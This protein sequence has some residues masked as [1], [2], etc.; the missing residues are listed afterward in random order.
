[1]L[2]SKCGTD[3]PNGS[4]FCFK[5]GTPLYSQNIE[6][7]AEPERK[8]HSHSTVEERRIVSFGK[9][10][11]QLRRRWVNLIQVILGIGLVVACIALAN[12]SKHVI[13]HVPVTSGQF[14]ARDDVILMNGDIENATLGIFIFGILAGILL[15]KG[16]GGLFRK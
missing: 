2:C 11:Q 1:V 3:L 6:Q 8:M 7:A 9:V 10:K 14:M 12:Y 15:T 5:C 4:N 13:N 16:I